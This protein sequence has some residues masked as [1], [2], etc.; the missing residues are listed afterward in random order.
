MTTSERRAFA[1]HEAWISQPVS[2]LFP[3]TGPRVTSLCRH[4]KESYTRSAHAGK[5]RGFCTER[6]RDAW[7]GKRRIE[8]GTRGPQSRRASP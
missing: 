2:I 1:L 3:P 5:V 6:C 4:C 8:Y 7:C